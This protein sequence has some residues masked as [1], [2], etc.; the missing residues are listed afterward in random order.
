MAWL[1]NSGG[2]EETMGHALVCPVCGGRLLPQEDSENQDSAPV[3]LNVDWAGSEGM[4]YVC[5]SCGYM[6][7]FTPEE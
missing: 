3:L 5:D 2:S 7:W 6:M 1:S 4:N